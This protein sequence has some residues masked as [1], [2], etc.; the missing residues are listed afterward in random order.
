MGNKTKFFFLLVVLVLYSKHIV[1][2]NTSQAYFQR[3]DLLLFWQLKEEEA[4]KLRKSLEQQREQA[5]NREE[6]LRVEASEKVF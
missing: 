2:K 4:K 6:E 1:S 3:C 5:K